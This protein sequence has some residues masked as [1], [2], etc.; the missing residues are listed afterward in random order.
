MRH[1]AVQRVLEGLQ[2]AVGAAAR[3]HHQDPA[4]EDDEGRQ[5]QKSGN[6]PAH[7]LRSDGTS[8]EVR[9]CC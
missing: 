1:P 3:H 4:Q 6:A 2:A 9:P 5:L 7:G 8:R